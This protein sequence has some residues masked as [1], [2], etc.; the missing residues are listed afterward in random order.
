M[1]IGEN[2]KRLRNANSLTQQEL[3]DRCELTKGYISQIERDLTSPSIATLTDI[4]EC[5]GTD[6][7]TFFNGAVDGKI[8]FK[9]DDVFVK[10]TDDNYIINWII[11]NAQKNK[12]E[13]ILVELDSYAKTKVDNPHEGEEFGY[14]L[15]GT[16]MLYYG[17]HAFKVKKGESFYFKTNKS[18]YIE[19]TSKNAARVIWVSTPP[20]F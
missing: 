15:S 20:N 4:L 13:P 19:N 1:D 10:E 6:L 11:P 16:I 9:E 7:G 18:H 2:I 14:I 17:N 12:M 5:L 3:A 8:V